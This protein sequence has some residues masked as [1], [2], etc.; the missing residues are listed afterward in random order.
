MAIKQDPEHICPYSVWELRP[1]AK[2]A[3]TE[4]LLRFADDIEI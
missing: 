1:T 3:S 4:V 2:G